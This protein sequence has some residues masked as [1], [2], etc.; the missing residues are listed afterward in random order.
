MNTD[1]ETLAGVA[2]LVRKK[3]TRKRKAQEGSTRAK[4]TPG[5]LHAMTDN[6]AKQKDG[7]TE[8]RVKTLEAET[9]LGRNQKESKENQPPL[10]DADEHVISTE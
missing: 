7:E 4:L 6:L 9:K 1:T 2:E 5:E 8:N 10:P 3:R